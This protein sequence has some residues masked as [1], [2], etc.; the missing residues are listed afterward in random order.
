MFIKFGV[1]T[2]CEKFPSKPVCREHV[3]TACN[4]VFTGSHK[5]ALV[6]S[7]TIP[8][9]LQIDWKEPAHMVRPCS[10]NGRRKI[11]QNNTEVE[12]K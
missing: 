3:I 2:L 4:A 10:K 6:L 12:P 7:A 8:K 5:S 9:Q 11:A 1:G